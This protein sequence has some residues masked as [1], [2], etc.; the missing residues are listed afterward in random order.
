M[1]QILLMLPVFAFVTSARAQF[2]K[3]DRYLGGY[4]S[5]N[6]SNDDLNT[7]NGQKNFY[8][9]F[10]P[11][12]T[13]FKTDRKATGFRFTLGYEN[14]KTK[15]TFG[16]QKREDWL[17]QAGLFGLRIFPLGKG[18][19]LST[20]A[21]G[22]IGYR[23][24]NNTTVAAPGDRDKRNEYNVNGYFTPGLGY[25]LTDRLVLGVN[26]NSVVGIGYSH[27]ESRYTNPSGVT[28]KQQADR[29]S[30]FSSLNNTTVGQLGFSFMWKLR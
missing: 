24:S 14:N 1:K 15:F 21:G 28:T 25:K 17:A 7:S 9:A 18:F 13:R 20:E 23:N 30:L 22:N 16:E 19:Y 29:L 12:F 2:T 3:G 10:S 27:V 5:F 6:Y 26:L 8:I 4:A 11:S